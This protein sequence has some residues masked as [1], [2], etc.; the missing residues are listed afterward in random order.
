MLQKSVIKNNISHGH[1]FPFKSCTDC[2]CCC[3]KKNSK[4]LIESETLKCIGLIQSD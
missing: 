1:E 2:E 3:I 4:G